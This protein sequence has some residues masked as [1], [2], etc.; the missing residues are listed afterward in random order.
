MGTVQPRI[1]KIGVDIYLQQLKEEIPSITREDVSN[2]RKNRR[3][4]VR[5]VCIPCQ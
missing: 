1:L 5:D 2:D 3:H 4:D